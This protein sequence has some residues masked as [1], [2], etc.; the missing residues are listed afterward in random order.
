LY[1]TKASPLAE[2]DPVSN[3]RQFTIKA[4]APPFYQ[5]QH[6]ATP[7][8]FPIAGAPQASALPESSRE[9]FAPLLGLRTDGRKE[10]N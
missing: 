1:T 5:K 8:S 10:V 9:Q 6:M 3:E 2:D 7:P 4:I